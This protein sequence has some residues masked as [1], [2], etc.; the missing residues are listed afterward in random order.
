M[1]RRDGDF[2]ALT[3][4]VF[5]LPPPGLLIRD[6]VIAAISTLT[7]P[8]LGMLINSIRNQGDKVV[9]EVPLGNEGDVLQAIFQEA[10][11]CTKNKLN[12]MKSPRLRGNDVN[13]IT[14]FHD[15]TG[16]LISKDASLLEFA[17]KVLEWAK[18]ECYT[19]TTK[20]ML[21]YGFIHERSSNLILGGDRYSALQLFKIE[22]Y[23]HGRDFLSSYDDVK[24]QLKHDIYW[25]ALLMAGLSL[26]FSGFI[27]DELIFV[28]IPEDFALYK[29]ED[30]LHLFFSL[31][32][33]IIYDKDKGLSVITHRVGY[34][35]G[36]LDPI[37]AFLQLL[38]YALVREW[39]EKFNFETLSQATIQIHRIRIGQAYT[40][41]ERNV[42]DLASFT[43]FAYKLL[44]QG[45]DST[46]KKIEDLLRN[47]Y[48]LSYGDYHS[49]AMKLY[50]AISGSYDVY[51][52]VYELGRLLTSTTK[53][54][55]TRIFNENDIRVLIDAIVT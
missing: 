53:R 27:N 8:P 39:R 54:E 12:L 30:A 34:S 7:G 46:L 48:E 42:G 17:L 2:M 26:T 28:T 10:C 51:S 49:I 52:L 13:V 9:V 5:K 50:Q 47:Y 29:E 11:D 23:E 6:F 20:F 3:Q 1:R 21:S 31:P 37:F 44:K 38:S 25:L 43:R 33:N 14:K 35:M 22:K 19:S 18:E 36:G 41:T 4:M 15:E 45:H 32:R 55:T 24:M 40:L 16:R